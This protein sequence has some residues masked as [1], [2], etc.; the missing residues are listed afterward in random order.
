ML[1]A[2]AVL[3]PK[4]KVSLPLRSA[5]SAGTASGSGTEQAAAGAGGAS[6]KAAIAP[7]RLKP[8]V[9]ARAGGGAGRP[10][11]AQAGPMGGAAGSAG[12]VSRQALDKILLKIQAK[13]VRK[14]FL[15]PV[16]EDL[17]GGVHLGLITS[18]LLDGRE[19]VVKQVVVNRF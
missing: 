4:I 16:T 10:A 11:G 1:H 14:I 6:S 17:V 12:S 5:A 9:S 8:G 19:V 13:D 2:G 7:S 18:C 15:K 3:K